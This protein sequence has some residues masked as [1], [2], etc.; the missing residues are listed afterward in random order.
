MFHIPITK[1]TANNYMIEF[2]HHSHDAPANYWKKENTICLDHIKINIFNQGDFS[3]FADNVC[4]HPVYGDI[5]ILP[6]YKMHSGQILKATYTDYYQLDIGIHSMN[7][8]LNG[9]LLIKELLNLSNSGCFFKAD[10]NSISKIFNL[11]ANAENHILKDNMPLAF[12]TIIEI[13]YE[14]IENCKENS[15]LDPFVITKTTRNVMKYIEKNFDKKISIEQIAKS[16]DLS[17]SYLSRVFKKETGMGI[18]EYIIKYRVLQASKFLKNHSVTNACYM[19]GFSDASHF[20]AVFKKHFN[21]TPK[22]YKEGVKI[23]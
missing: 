14:I 5:C 9:D 22:E 6:P 15:S 4:Y 20:I 13:L 10:K 23:I 1:N 7:N 19:C 8:I 16:C 12:A 21:C 17:P 3:V 2:T 18:H 11:C